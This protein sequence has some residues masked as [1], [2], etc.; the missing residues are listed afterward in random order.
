MI[1]LDA[2]A[3]VDAVLDQPTAGWVLD[4]MADQEIQT[5]AHQLAEVVS[6]IARLHRAGGV[7]QKAAQAALAEAAGLAQTV[8]VATA[9]HLTRA[10]APQ[11]RIRIPDGLY[12]AVA[13]ERACPLVTT[14]ERLARAGAP[15]EVLTPLTPA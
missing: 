13:E 3:L 14:D 7:T 8:I 1:V 5:P 12:V 10:L 9:A 15:C 6:A 11:D 2:A 4:R